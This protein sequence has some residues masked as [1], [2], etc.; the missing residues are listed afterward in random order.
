MNQ[1]NISLI[2]NSKKYLMKQQYLTQLNLIY[3]LAY[4][5]WEIHAILIL[6]YSAYITHQYLDK[7]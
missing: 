2:L 4:I 7:F 5:I 1:I 3:V 6:Y